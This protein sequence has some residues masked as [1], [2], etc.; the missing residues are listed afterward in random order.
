MTRREHI[1]DVVLAC[2]PPPDYYTA[3][4][5]V[6]R[7]DLVVIIGLS[8]HDSPDNQLPADCKNLIII[9]RTPTFT[10]GRQRSSSTKAR[11]R[12]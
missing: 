10:T 11:A 9:N 8:M 4:E 12:L 1:P 3:K 7:A 5:E 6:Q 2:E